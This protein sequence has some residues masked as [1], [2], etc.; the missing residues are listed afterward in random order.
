MR[1]TPRQ[2]PAFVPPMLLRRVTS[3]PEGPGW[4]YEV[5]WDGHRMQAIKN[6]SSVRLLSRNGADYSRRF[7]DLAQAIS[8]LKP[9]TR[10]LDGEVVATDQS[11]RP[12]F[13]ALQAS[14]RLPNGWHLA[15]YA[16]DLLQLNTRKL[17]T[18][19]LTDRQALLHEILGPPAAHLRPSTQLQGTVDQIVA[20]VR[21]HGLEG[22]VA[23]RADSLYESG[24]R[25]GAWV[26]LPL[27]QTGTFLLGG[28]RRVGGL[29]VLLVGRFDSGRF[30]FAGK[31]THGLRGLSRL[32]LVAP[33]N[34]R[35]RKC[36]FVDLPD[37][38]VDHFG[39][40]VTP[41]EMGA[42]SWLKPELELSVAFNEWTRAGALRQA[43]LLKDTHE[44]E[45]VHGEKH[46][47]R[48]LTTVQVSQPERERSNGRR[49]RNQLKRIT[50][51]RALAL[52]FGR[53]PAAGRP[54]RPS[55]GQ[56]LASRP[57]AGLGQRPAAS[58]GQRI[59]LLASSGQPSAPASGLRYR[60]AWPSLRRRPAFLRSAL[61]FAPVGGSALSS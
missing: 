29:A 4:T 30:K 23:K 5:R 39:E 9:H 2:A 15:F 28:F 6:G 1:R 11:G 16:F 45:H 50:S 24:K 38:K 36:P 55:A 57:A 51:A 32:E 7:P 58:L 59:R 61:R 46:S 12:S 48:C 14:P 17:T 47:H 34:L 25:S 13:Q 35:L 37:R 31:V 49:N 56:R 44:P 43:E 3:L 33:E 22:V 19:T 20:A 60:P 26:K 54:R 40:G 27:K 53:G 8:R 18:S 42:F 52:A 41:E 21:Q 10:H